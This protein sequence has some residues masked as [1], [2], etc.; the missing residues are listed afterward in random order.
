MKA[1]HRGNGSSWKRITNLA[2]TFTVA[3]FLFSTS[4]G[5]A[6]NSTNTLWLSVASVSNGWVNLILHGT[7]PGT[8]Y[9]LLSKQ[10]LAAPSWSNAAAMTGATNQ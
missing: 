4:S 6:G 3:A 8:N 9:V 5:F 2:G 10:T 7:T 1:I